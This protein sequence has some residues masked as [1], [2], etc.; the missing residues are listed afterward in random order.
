MLSLTQLAHVRTYLFKLHHPSDLL[1][2]HIFSLVSCFSYGM[3]LNSHLAVFRGKR[4]PF[5]SKPHTL[6]AVVPLAVPHPP[7]LYI[8]WL[9]PHPAGRIKRALGNAFS[10]NERPRT[11]A[12][13]DYCP[14][15][16]EAGMSVF[17]KCLSC[18]DDLTLFSSF[19]SVE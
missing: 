12:V 7:L 18:S 5:S 3:L 6:L 16:F 9:D 19:P 10:F 14:L 11:C 8:Y 17:S 2:P 1:P 15:E 13:V 4:A